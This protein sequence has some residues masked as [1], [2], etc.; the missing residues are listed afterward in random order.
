MS[1]AA[2]GPLYRED[3]VTRKTGKWSR[4]NVRYM[5]EY[6][7]VKPPSEDVPYAA[8]IATLLDTP[9]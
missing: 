3:V 4:S 5:N 1:Q 8:T 2:Q 6:R 9:M 7:W